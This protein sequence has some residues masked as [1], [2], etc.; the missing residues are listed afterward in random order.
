[1]N[2]YY[3]VFESESLSGLK[4]GLRV[5]AADILER[6]IPLQIEGE[7]P[8]QIVRFEIWEDSGRI[9]GF[10]AMEHMIERT[11]VAGG[12]VVCAEL[13]KEVE[14]LDLSGFPDEAHDKRIVEIVRRVAKVITSA[15]EEC[16]SFQFHIYDQDG[17]RIVIT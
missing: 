16:G 11:D 1:M 4:E 6:V 12:Q 14:A 5:F 7:Q 8:W 2:D 13:A 15:A 9:I 10:A 17:N 3:R